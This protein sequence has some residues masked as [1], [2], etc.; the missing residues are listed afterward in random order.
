MRPRTWTDDQLREAVATCDN[1]NQVCKCLG[2]APGAR[3]YELLRRHI[4]RL[5][6]QAE[7][8]PPAERSHRLRRAWTDHDLRT[9]VAASTTLSGVLRALGYNPSGGMHRYVSKRIANLGLDTSHFVG[10]SWAKGVRRPSPC[11]IPLPEILVPNST[12]TNT[13]R[14]RTR[15]VAAGLKPPHCECCGLDAWM[16]EPLPLALDHINGDHTD[17]RIENLRILCPNCHALTVTW[18]GRNTKPK[19]A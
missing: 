19:P 6:L 17:N 7:H 12:Y 18:C 11:R 5:E 10:R 16:G 13:A 3:T 4:A 8:L 14:L 9:V 15:L 1:L 2:I